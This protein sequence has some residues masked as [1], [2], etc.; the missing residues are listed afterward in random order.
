MGIETRQ[1]IVVRLI[2]V[3]DQNARRRMHDGKAAN[4]IQKFVD[5]CKQL[6]GA[7]GIGHVGVAAGGF[8]FGLVACQ[9]I[10]RNDDDRNRFQFGIGLHPPCSFVAVHD[11]QLNVHQDQVG[12]VLGAWATA[13]SPSWAS[14]ISIDAAQE[15][16]QD[17]PVVFLVFDHEDTF[18]H[19]G[20]TCRSTLRGTLNEKVDPWPRLELDPQPA[21]MHFHNPLRNGEAEA[22]TAFFLCGGQIG[23]LELFED[24]VLILYGDA[25]TGIVH[26]EGERAVRGRRLD[27]DFALVG[28]LDRIADEIEQDL[29][30]PA[31]VAVRGRQCFAEARPLAPVSCFSPAIQPS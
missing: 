28:E 10:R 22:G 29:R 27:R 3:D 18:A 21:A 17:L 13:A 8:R 24:F 2:V 31:L 30:E 26:R 1:D 5:L 12:P 9:R 4:Q 23:L 20:S 19:A 14:S 6:A 25:W 7:V 16:A 11:W 15:V